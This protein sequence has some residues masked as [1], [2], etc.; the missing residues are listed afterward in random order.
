MKNEHSTD[1]LAE[2]LIRSAIQMMCA[3]VHA[4]TIIEKRNSE[5]ENGLIDIDDAEVLE[6]QLNAI[7]NVSDDLEEYSQIRRNDMITLYKMYG[8]KGD[9]EQ[10]CMVKHLG[11]AAMTAFEAYQASDDNPALFDSYIRK[12]KAFVKSLSAFLGTEIT[13]CSACFSDML[14]GDL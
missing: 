5:L 1:G 7:Q 8:E 11:T 13:D 10:W 6:K 4:K 3:E 14:K 2:D 9:K 12:N